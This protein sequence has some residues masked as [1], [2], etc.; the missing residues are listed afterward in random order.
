MILA[1][2]VGG[3]KTVLALYE[4]GVGSLHKVREQTYSSTT[5][6][7]LSSMCADFMQHGQGVRIACFGVPGA[8]VNGTCKTTNLP[9]TITETGLAVTLGIA[10]VKLINDLQ[11]AGYGMLQLPADELAV[12][13]PGKRVPGSNCGVIAAGTGL[14]E[15][16]LAWTGER[17][18]PVASEGGHATFAPQNDLEHELRRFLARRIGTEESHVSWERVLSGPGLANIYDFLKARGAHEEDPHVTSK[19]KAGADKASVVGL[20]AVN[21]NDKLCGAAADMFAA[22]YGAE[23]GNV[24][25]KFAATGGMF[26]GGGMAPKL[27]PVLQRAGFMKAFVA[28]GRFEELLRNLPVHIALND[29][30]PL[31]GA[32]RFAADAL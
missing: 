20:E 26:I 15:G 22:L 16:L 7:S 30:A 6:R 12:I 28:K 14:G 4:S 31:I 21:G 11:A 18:L 8:V 24:A 25:L 10:R 3:T 5:L 1:G 29:K 27:L 17:Y 13:N 19:L 2:D 32:A 23:A 9:W